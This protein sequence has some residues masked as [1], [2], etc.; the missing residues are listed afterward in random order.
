M[1]LSGIACT[2]GGDQILVSGFEGNELATVSRGYVFEYTAPGGN[3][4]GGSSIV[5]PL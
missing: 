4:N 5:A 1:T 2:S 3:D